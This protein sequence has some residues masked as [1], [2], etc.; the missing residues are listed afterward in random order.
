MRGALVFLVALLVAG[1]GARPEAYVFMLDPSF[2]PELVGTQADGFTAPDGLI[3]HDGALIMA[4]EGGSAIR[5]WR[6][7]EGVRTLAGRGAG[8]R[9]PEDLV[10]D[11]SG[12]LYFSDDDAGGVRRI[13]PDGRI[14]LLAGAAQGLASTEAIAITPE[15]TVL[16]GDQS[17]HR[18]LAI[19]SDGRVAT[20]LRGIEKPESFAFDNA[21][22]LWIA[23]NE[24]DVLYRVRRG[25]QLER[26]V[27]GRRGFS[28]ESLF[29]AGGALWISDSRN[30]I[31][32]R[33]RE[34]EGLQAVAAFAGELENVQGLTVDPA[35][36]VYLSVQTDLRAGRSFIL[37]LRRR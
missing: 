33:Y 36:N 7:G 15:G 30:H 26:V 31:L 5:V 10:R 13:D 27:A 8:L 25:G 1:C 35:G 2:Q 29:F 24:E 4:D 3:W 34:G 20:A 28:P 11:A 37:R 17:G 6:P 16:A 23:D 12:N 32:H 22:T 18:V 19:S 21:G 14:S 9:S